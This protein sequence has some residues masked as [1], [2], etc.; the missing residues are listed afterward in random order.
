MLN[1][2]RDKRKGHL[3]KFRDYRRALLKINRLQN[4]FVT[5]SSDSNANNLQAQIKHLLHLIKLTPDII[6]IK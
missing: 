4:D 3:L 1:E 2:Q 6:H 5:A